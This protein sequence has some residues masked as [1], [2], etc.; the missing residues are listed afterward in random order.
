[1]APVVVVRGGGDLATGAAVRLHRAGFPVI[2]LEIERPLAVRR[3]VA[4]AEAVYAGE[5]E[6]EGTVGRRVA[7]A[8]EALAVLPSGVIPVLVDG[9]GASLKELQPAVLVDGR[10][11]KMASEL[12]RSVA[13]LV[14]G[15]GPGFVAG[16]DCHAVVETRRGHH[17]GRVLWQGSADPDT[18]VPEPVEGYDVDRV[19]RAAQSGV[20][21]GLR[22]I[23]AIVEQGEPIFAVDGHPSLAPFPGAVRGL[24]HDG[25]EVSVGAKVGDLDPR[26]EPRYCLEISDKSLAVGG[27]VLEAIL[28]Q[29]ELR[30]ALGS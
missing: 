3:K 1:M 6:I 22:P 19:L 12:P 18:Q 9:S 21:Q 30:R 8:T 14:V 10:M 16:G 2:V 29:P 11:R 7:D 17:L 4:L 20:V 24:L 26:R 13:A 25:L 5:I 15:L 23:G 28:S 27:G